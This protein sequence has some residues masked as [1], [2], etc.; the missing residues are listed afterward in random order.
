[1]ITLLVHAGSSHTTVP[2]TAPWDMENWRQMLEQG[3]AKC[4][5]QG[6]NVKSCLSNTGYRR[7][8]KQHHLISG[9]QLMLLPLQIC[10]W[11]AAAA[12]DLAENDLEAALLICKN[13]MHMG[14]AVSC[15]DSMWLDRLEGEGMERQA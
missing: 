15:A 9:L 3:M 5:F 12:L 7:P 14:G 10:S 2:H 8:G 6:G 13:T 4:A 11:D 1:M